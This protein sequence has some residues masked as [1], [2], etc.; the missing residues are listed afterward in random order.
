VNRCEVFISYKSENRALADKIRAGLHHAGIGCWV[1]HHDITP[2]MS[3]P[4]QISDAIR[5]CRVV[6]VILTTQANK[7]PKHII[8]EI[9]IADQHAKV[10]LPIRCE[11]F[12][13][14]SDFAYVLAVTQVLDMVDAADFGNDQQMDTLV[15]AIQFHLD[16]AGSKF[17]SPAK[18]VRDRKL[19][20]TPAAL[21]PETNKLLPLSDVTRA[22]DMGQE[23]LKAGETKT[24][25]AR[26][27]FAS[28]SGM[29]RPVVIEAM[30]SGADLT[31]AG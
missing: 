11:P 2:G 30:I 13:L 3:Y 25:S 29:P 15:E 24:A 16:D 7:E 4:G 23:L 28:L 9:T 18:S 5:N 19:S 1:S 22:I 8:R 10:I 26:T 31:P 14:N 21:P 27:I 12:E 17:E 6:L 20:S